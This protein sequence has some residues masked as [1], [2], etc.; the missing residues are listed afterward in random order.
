MSQY[1]FSKMISNSL[2]QTE[3]LI[4]PQIFSR[5]EKERKQIRSKGMKQFISIC[6]GGN[7]IKASPSETR[8]SD[9][10]SN[11]LQIYQNTLEK[12]LSEINQT[13][14]QL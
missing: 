12:L 1:C 2:D 6:K 13:V 4:H 3:P 5:V 7:K 10:A 11:I 14:Q 9:Q 8:S